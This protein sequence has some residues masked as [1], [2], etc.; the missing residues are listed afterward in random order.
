M[1][2][3]VG[4]L[5]SLKVPCL[6]NPVGTVGVCYEV[7]NIGGPNGYSFIFQNG[8]YDGFSHDEVQD[9]LEFQGIDPSIRDYKF[10]N[11]M[12]LSEDFSKEKLGIVSKVKD[13]HIFETF[14]SGHWRV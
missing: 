7:Y 11:V 6:G 12:R 14:L 3:I 13:P 4:S 2:P 5:Y 10:T 8:R 1:N 9:F